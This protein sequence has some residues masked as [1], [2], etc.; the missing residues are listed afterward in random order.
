MSPQLRYNLK[1]LRRKERNK[2]AR[3]V[4]VDFFKSD[5]FSM[6]LTLLNAC[7]LLGVDNLNT[8][9]Q[10]LEERIQ[11]LENLSIYDL[12]VLLFIKEMLSWEEEARPHFEDLS[13]KLNIF[14]S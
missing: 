8:N 2:I 7:T 1:Q 10:A 9:K 4:P 13:A 11:L 12:N 6:G 3:Y 5:V 14:R